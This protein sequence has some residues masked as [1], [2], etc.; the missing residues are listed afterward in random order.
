MGPAPAA[1]GPVRAVPGEHLLPG[2]G[3]AGLLR[4]TDRSGA[5]RVSGAPARR[6][7]GAGPQPAAARRVEPDHARRLRAGPPLDRRSLR[8]PGRRRG[9]H[10]QYAVARASRASSSCP[11]LRDPA[12]AARSRPAD[13]HWPA[14]LCDLARRL[15]DPDG[16]LVRLPGDLHDDRARRPGR[17][18][19]CGMGQETRSGDR[20]I[21]YSL[22]RSP[23]WRRPRS[24]SLTGASPSN[25]A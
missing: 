23:P 9:L 4:A 8:G 5:A 14:H 6:I 18:P 25:R 19:D 10:L 17:G 2:A 11:C 24:I 15:D 16:L 21:R 20:R 7:P 13:R 3:R 12:G 1:A 22:R